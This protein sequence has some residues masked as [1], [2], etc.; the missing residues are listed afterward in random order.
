MIA[1][2]DPRQ[3]TALLRGADLAQR[4]GRSRAFAVRE[5]APQL[6]ADGVL[7]RRG[8]AWY[9]RPVDVETWLAGRW[10]PQARGAR[11]RASR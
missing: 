3:R 9:G 7:F 2:L 8:R 11:M 5:I 4:T 6:V 1:D 10:T